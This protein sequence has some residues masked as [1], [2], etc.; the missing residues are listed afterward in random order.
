MEKKINWKKVIELL[1]VFGITIGLMLLVGVI[2][3]I[4]GDKVSS[5]IILFVGEAIIVVPA[6]IYCFIEKLDFKKDLGIRKIKISTFFLSIVLGFLLMPIAS[7]VNVLTQF[8]VPNTMVQASDALLEGSKLIML[9]IAGVLGPIFEE[10]AFRGIFHR[11][12]A[13]YTTPVLGII[14][15]AVLFGIMH[16]NLNQLCYAIL[17]GVVFA[18][19]NNCSRSIFSSVIMHIV[20]NSFNMLTLILASLAMEM[21]GENL[22]EST[23]A[24][25]NNTQGLATIAIVYFVLAAIA[26]AIMIPVVKAI[27]KIESP[28]T[29]NSEVEV[30]EV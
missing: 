25:R 10:F 29:E 7:F 4:V 28:K 5:N 11:E 1:V 23:E 9:L 21:L 15:S 13:K 18:W 8:F 20:I 3:G 22:A 14:I 30:E 19:V 24:V 26:F 2:T 17:L 12:F 16:M 6:L 27:K